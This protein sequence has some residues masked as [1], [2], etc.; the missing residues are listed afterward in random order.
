MVLYADINNA[1]D[2]LLVYYAS[3]IE[4]HIIFQCSGNTTCHS[5]GQIFRQEKP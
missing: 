4:L 1:E 5:Y 2:I 3:E